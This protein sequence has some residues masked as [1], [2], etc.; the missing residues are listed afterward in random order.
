M[1]EGTAYDL[2]VIGSG[3]A[4]QVTSFRA[5][6]AGWSVAVIDHLPF[7][8]TCALRGC[9]PKK[10]LIS[11]AEAI[12]TARRMRGRGAA[13]EL[14]ISWPEL[15]A[16]KRTFTDPVPANQERRYAEHG[17]D[18]FHGKAR[19]TG[20]DT[21][22]IGG[23]TVQARHV[24]IATGAHPV[25]LRFPGAGHVVTSDRFLELEQL[26]AR[27]VMVGGGYI[28][29]EFSHIA[30]RAGA[31]VTVLQRAERILTRFEPEL[32]GWLMEKFA[33]IGVEVRTGTVVE[34]IEEVDHGFRVHGRKGGEETAIEADLVVH[35]AGRVSDLD[36]NLSAA[37]IAVESGRLVLNEFLQSASNPAVY[38]AGD[39][40]AK[41]PP[42]T[43]VSSHD[44]KVVAANLLEGNRH[45]PDYRGVPSV[46]FSLPP[47]AAVGMSEAAVRAERLAFRVNCQKV[48]DWYTARR[49][50]ETVYGYKTLIEE[51]SGRILGAHLVGPHVD[52][53]INLF[54]LAIRRNLTAEDLRQTIFAYPTGASDIGSML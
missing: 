19:F 15:I 31:K 46:A 21:I 33:E 16:F 4:A 51:G 23:Q 6:A 1:S 17:I 49:V 32:V 11:G 47:I 9:D 14:R 20:R 24:V 43:P 41:G 35:A 28:A 29:A 2:A 12:D 10:M 13:G 52:E 42:L 39:A 45:R 3:T 18:T 34:A 36:L 22:A 30:A 8:G 54:A 5:R 48:P 50:G 26:P 38:A 37:G 53:V 7:G 27:I 44:G 40:A 25:P